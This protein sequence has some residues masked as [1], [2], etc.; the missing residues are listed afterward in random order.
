ML[1]VLGW[2]KRFTEAGADM[3]VS[4]GELRFGRVASELPFVDTGAIYGILT[5]RYTREGTAAL[6]YAEDL[7][8]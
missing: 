4:P 7:F 1:V 3:C 8:Q 5:S 6:P 2:G